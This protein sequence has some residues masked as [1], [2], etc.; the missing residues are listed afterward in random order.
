MVG[1]LQVGHG[2]RRFHPEPRVLGLA[3]EEKGNDDLIH[4]SMRPLVKGK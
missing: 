2:P 1:S 4:L 3:A